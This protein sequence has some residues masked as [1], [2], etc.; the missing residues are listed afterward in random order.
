MKNYV[1]GLDYGSDSV[2]ALLLDAATGQEI[3]SKVHWYKRWKEHKYCDTAIN[4]FRQHP[5]DHIEGLEAVI[6]SVVTKSSIDSKLIKGIC[7]DTNAPVSLNLRIFFGQVRVH[8]E[9]FYHFEGFL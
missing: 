2:R 8:Y 3:A 9:C 5:L 6:K 1:I 7:I 4:Q